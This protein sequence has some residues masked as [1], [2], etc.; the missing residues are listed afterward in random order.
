M[1]F[2]NRSFIYLGLPVIVATALLLAFFFALPGGAVAAPNAPE[3]FGPTDLFFSEYIEGSSNNKALE[4]YNGTGADIIFTGQ[5]SVALYSNGATTPGNVLVL[6]GAT[7]ADDDVY[8]IA[9]ASADSAILSVADTTSTVTYFN[10]NDAI[11]LYKDGVLIDVLGTIGDASY[12]GSEVTLVRK[13]TVVSGSDPYDAAEWDSYAQNTF[14]YLGT[15]TV[16]VCGIGGADL[17]V[18]KT[19]P[20][21][22]LAGE[23]LVY[24]III[25]NNKIDPATDV[26]LTDTLPLSTT[27]V[28]DNSG[29]LPTHPSAREYVWDFGSVISNTQMTFN[30]TVTVDAAVTYGT[31]LT[32]TVTI[33]TTAAEDDPTTNLDEALTTIVPSPSCGDPVTRIHVIQGNGGASPEEGNVHAIEG[34][35]VADYQYPGGGINGF[36]V[37]EDD[38][39]VD[40]DPMT[41]EGILVY[42]GY[43]PIVDVNVDD[44]VRVVGT[45]SEYGGMTEL[46]SISSVEICPAVGI[47]SPATP[48]MP[49]DSVDDWEW[50]EGMSVN[51][52][53][54]L[55]VTEHYYL[56]RYGEISLSVNDR[57]SNPTQVITPGLDANTLQDLNDR[58]QI[59]L[60]DAITSQN[61]DPIIYPSPELS[62]TNTLRG[63]D[64]VAEL[65]GVMYHAYGLYL[66]EP[67]GSITFTHDNP[68][69]MAP[70]LVGGSLQVASFNVLN[71]FSTIDDGVNDIC[72]PSQDMECRGADSASEFTRQ[73]DKIINAIVTMDADIVGLMEIENHVTDAA[74]DNLI[75]GLNTIAG[76]GTYAKVASGSIGTDAIKVALIYQPANAT[77]VGSY[78]VLDDSF[79]ANYQDDYNRPA[80]A[81]TFADAN[82]GRVTVVVN[83]LKSKGSDCNA[84]GDPDTGDGQ[85]N[86]NLTRTTAANILLN[87]LA[88][89]PTDSG[90]YNFLIIGDLNSY[91]ME[92]PIVALETGG[93]TNLYRAFSEYDYSYVFDGQWGTLDYSLASAALLPDITGA[94]AWHINSDEPGVLDYNEEYKSTHQL[95]SLYAPDQYRASDHDPIIVGL[96]LRVAPVASFTSNSPLPS[97]ET[98]VFTNT[99]TGTEPLTYLWDFGDEITST[100][101]NPTHIYADAGNYTVT[102]TVTNTLGADSAT[103][104]V[105]VG[106]APLASFNSNS[107]LLLG[108]TAVFTSTST[109][110]EPL[111]YLWDFGDEITSTLENP[112]HEYAET[113]IYTVTLTVTNAFGQDTAIANFTVGEMPVAGFTSNSPITL[114]EMAIFTSTSTGSTPLTYLWDFGDGITSTLENPTHVYGQ[115]GTYTVTLTVENVYG[116]DVFTDTFTVEPFM[117]YL[118]IVFSNNN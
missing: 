25:S 28:S 14:D 23:N 62:A 112:A 22:V 58:S 19:G 104:T 41:S 44:V 43:S 110:T 3:G 109:G 6:N 26:V 52:T 106:D 95:T 38:A 39:N 96:D 89:D 114:G 103:G 34:V 105:I 8:V 79:D 18:S 45:V 59:V 101:K 100:L 60:D 21:S 42:D 47:A 69:P 67:V 5:Y 17:I 16:G 51:F 54:T 90:S 94:T 82:G 13:D 80:L 33:T 29:V 4:I 91:A 49:V 115:T 35:V 68:R 64:S 111:T 1:T 86:C 40:D 63:G 2:R 75:D 76:A 15:H 27:Y 72:G 24:E 108:E 11:A 84:I 78:A 31:V 30:L 70:D 113:G 36:F 48:T 97:G 87:W 85:G 88:T 117:I 74:V 83:H 46:S 12:W 10:G 73:R 98:A 71:Y 118:P 66:V 93:F 56:G 53:Q 20:D 37:Q 7:L 81:Q 65:T 92:D 77:P 57:L 116:S 32:N 102:L 61:P 99:S 50:Y 107:P 9:N 55:Y